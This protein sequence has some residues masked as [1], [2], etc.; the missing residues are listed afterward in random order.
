MGRGAASEALHQVERPRA[1]ILDHDGPLAVPQPTH[2]PSQVL[3]PAEEV[4]VVRAVGSPQPMEPG[5][6]LLEREPDDEVV[7]LASP[8]IERYTTS[9]S[10]G[11]SPHFHK[12]YRGDATRPRCADCVTHE[13]CARQ[14]L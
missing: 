12:T 6:E 11:H 3:A 10:K 8:T 5:L 4:L 13:M 9:A 2:V 14:G 7:L 1:P